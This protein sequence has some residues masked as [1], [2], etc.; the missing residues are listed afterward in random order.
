MKKV[1]MIVVILT[2]LIACS[3]LPINGKLDG[4]WQI[5]Q[6]EYKDGREEHPERAYYSVSL[7]TINVM[8]VN[9]QGQTGNMEY[10]NDSLFVTM[11]VSTVDELRVFG[12]N[13][14]EQRFAV[15]ELTASRLVL[16]S[17]YARISFRKF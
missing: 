8:Q 10:T 1:L 13:D 3:K 14:T 9:G 15:K 12:M 2:Q 6:I 16:E 4:R 17:G 11:P 5:M 7:H